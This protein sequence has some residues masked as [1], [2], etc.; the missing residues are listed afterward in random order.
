MRFEFRF[1]EPGT[2]DETI[3]S[4][5]SLGEGIR[6]LVDEIGGYVWGAPKVMTLTGDQRL[7]LTQ[8][9][10]PRASCIEVLWSPGG[11]LLATDPLNA[12]LR[13]A[14]LGGLTDCSLTLDVDDETENG[15]LFID[16]E[17]PNWVPFD[18]PLQPW[19][20]A[21]KV[22]SYL[23][24]AYLSADERVQMAQR[25]WETAKM[26]FEIAAA[27]RQG[28]F[29]DANENGMSWY[30]ISQLT[31]VAQSRAKDIATTTT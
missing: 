31:G 29:R 1:M 25:S 22:P 6:G 3:T 16:S 13:L 26:V 14:G 27:G 7:Q 20:K 18:S 17:G 9:N 4:F 24:A 19:N 8:S 11:V 10:I 28:A 21:T 12:L 5:S 30:R 15:P 2:D 23:A